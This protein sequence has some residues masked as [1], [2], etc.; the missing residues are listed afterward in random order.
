LFQDER[1][2]LIHEGT[3]RLPAPFDIEGQLSLRTA[4][5]IDSYF[6]RLGFGCLK[7]RRKVIVGI[8]P[9]PQIIDREAIDLA[10]SFCP[11]F[12]SRLALSGRRYN[13]SELMLAGWP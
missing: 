8:E 7:M 6:P 5:K 10:Q 12:D 3:R 11:P 9:Q 13:A 4:Q 1:Q 2:K